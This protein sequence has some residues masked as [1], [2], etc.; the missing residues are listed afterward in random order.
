VT[1]SPDAPLRPGTR[2]RRRDR[3]RREL[4]LAAVRLFDERGFDG[5]TVDDIADAADVS[6]S[7][8]FRLFARKEDVIFYDLPER[9]EAMRADFAAADHPTAWQTVRNAFV[10]NAR[11]WDD[12]AEAFGLARARLFHRE[13]ALQARYLEMCQDWEDVVA[14]LVAAERGTD[15]RADLYARVVAGSSVSAFRAAFIARIN[16]GGTE[17]AALLADAFTMLERGLPIDGSTG[18]ASPV[19]GS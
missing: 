16:G 15:P 10:N 3:A 1:T 4:A 5:T 6:A 18:P 9:L 8:F 11:T 17:I 19:A 7:T 12:D 14:G 2:E 13:R